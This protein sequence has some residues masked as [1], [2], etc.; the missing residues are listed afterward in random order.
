MWA[1]F[2]R[3]R[4]FVAVV[5]PVALCR[6]LYTARFASPRAGLCSRARGSAVCVRSLPRYLLL[7]WLVVFSSFAVVVTS[8]LPGPLP[9]S[10]F[11]LVLSFFGD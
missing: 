10:L 7:L 11:F 8:V 9:R 3:S 1:V 4:V 6:T 2:C 5:V